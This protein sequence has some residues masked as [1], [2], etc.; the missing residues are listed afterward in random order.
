MSIQRRKEKCERFVVIDR[1]V[2]LYK[3]E[4]KSKIKHLRITF[5]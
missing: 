2:T 4:K 3:V 5:N 1:F